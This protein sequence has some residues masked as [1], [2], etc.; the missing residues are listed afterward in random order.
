MFDGFVMKISEILEPSDMLLFQRSKKV[1]TYGVLST[2]GVST[3]VESV[4]LPCRISHFKWLPQKYRGSQIRSGIRYNRTFA[5]P[6]SGVL[7][8]GQ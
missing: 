8:S 6:W 1:S 3:Y 5:A 7:N 4:Q 2:Y